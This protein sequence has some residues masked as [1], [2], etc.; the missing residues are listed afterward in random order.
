MNQFKYLGSVLTK[1]AY[2][3]KEIRSRIAMAKKAF[4]KKRTL[5]TSSLNLELRKNLVK[6]YIWSIALYGSE[7]W[8]LRKLEKKYLESFEMW[9]WR[10]IENIKWMDMVTNEEV[11]SRVGEKKSIIHTIRQRKA[12]W[13]G[14]ILRRNC[15]LH[16]VV[17]G[18]LEGTTRLGRRRIQLLDDLREKRKYWMLKEEAE[19][20][21]FWKTKFTY[22]V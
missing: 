13:V 20:R 19:D 12:N 7:T 10:Q 9:C 15:L 22:Q 6:C 3:T 17:E 4:M 5:L 14:H 18:R 2:C 16:D 21:Q 8:T 11:L 1:D